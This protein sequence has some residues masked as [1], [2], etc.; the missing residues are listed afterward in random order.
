[1]KENNKL[2]SKNFV[3]III[4]NFL[5]FLNHLMVLSAFPLFIT[6]S[7]AFAEIGSDTIAG[8]CATV[9]SLIGVV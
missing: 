8:A 1:M 9:F 5:V 2:W 3:L 6:S 7:K 4:I